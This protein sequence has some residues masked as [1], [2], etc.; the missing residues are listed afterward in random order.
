[1]SV[2]ID[3][4]DV[5]ADPGATV[6]QILAKLQERRRLIV[7]LLIDGHAPD[8]SHMD[9]I[10]SLPVGDRCLYIET[11]DPADAARDTLAQAQTGLVGAAQFRDQCVDLLRNDQWPAAM[12]R[13]GKCL[14]SWLQAQQS[15]AAI[16]RLFHIDLAQ[17]EV[18]GRPMSGVSELFASLLRRIQTAI[19]NTDIVDLIDLLVYQSDESAQSWRLALNQLSEMIPDSVAVQSAA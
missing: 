6:G 15:A 5:A 2:T 17:L 9:A 12:E 1:M 7:R 13:L 19:Q 4:Q 18:A 14:A 10:R 8:L 11:T 16:A 3:Q